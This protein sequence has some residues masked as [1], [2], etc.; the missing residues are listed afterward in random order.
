MA[1]HLASSTG[2]VTDG[3]VVWH[4]GVASWQRTANEQPTGRLPGAGARPPRP[5]I[6]VLPSISGAAAIR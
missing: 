1:A 2:V 3:N 6:W 4:S 5:T